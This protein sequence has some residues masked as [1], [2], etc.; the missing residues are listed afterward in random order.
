MPYDPTMYLGTAAYYV[1]GR[2]AYS[3]ALVPAL[4][5]EFGLDGTGRMLDVGCGPGVLATALAG[6][7][8]EVVGLDPDKDMLAEGARRAV[9]AEIDNVR[10]VQALAED[11]PTLELGT[12][13]L[14]TFGQSFHWTDREQVAEIIYD[15]LEPGG[16]L[17]LI[18]HM[19]EGRPQ[20]QGPDHPPIPHEAIRALIDRYLGPRR[21]AGQ[22]FANMPSESHEDVLLR[23][24]FGMPRQLF[25]PGRPDIIQDIDGVLANYF[26]TSF[27]APH[28][29]GERLANFEADMRAE[30]TAHSSSGLFWDW[31]GDTAVLI[32]TKPK[33]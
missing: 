25:C 30:L 1:H 27:A 21:R 6:C 12:F 5:A 32:A 20:P 24:R 2:P 33:A 10:W 31:P 15:M 19:V 14:V 9:A 8:A 29:F 4:T 17:A 3:P 16:A 26:S 13:R 22:G 11:I 18:G 28:L 23:T 7:F